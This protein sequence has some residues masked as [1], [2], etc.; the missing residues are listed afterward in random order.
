[1]R[2]MRSGKA[3]SV[4]NAA[5]D[6]NTAFIITASWA[7]ICVRNAD[8]KDRILILTHMMSRLETVWH[9]VWRTDFFLRIIRDS[10][11]YIISLPPMQEYARLDFP[12]S[13]LMIC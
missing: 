10:I 8:S 9:S 5:P 1:M 12:G 13:I 3:V 11:M 6:W 7:I 4:R 2:R